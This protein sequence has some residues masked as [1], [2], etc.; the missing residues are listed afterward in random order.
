MAVTRRCRKME[1]NNRG[2]H[3]SH[4]YQMKPGNRAQYNEKFTVW[5]VRGLNPDRNKRLSLH[6]NCPDRL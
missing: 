4:F 1:V 3:E 5:K 6:K 2:I